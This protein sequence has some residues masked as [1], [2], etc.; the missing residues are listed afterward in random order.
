MTG[1]LRSVLRLV[2]HAA[3][4]A[5]LLL[6]A[7]A[8]TATEA[9]AQGL[10]LPQLSPAAEVKQQVGIG[11]ITVRYASPAV[12][13]RKIFGTLVPFGELWRTGANGA[14]TIEFTHDVSVSGTAVPAGKYSVFS[15]PGKDEWTLIL[16]KN[17]NQGGTRNYK[18]DLD[19][20]RVKV[21]PTAIAPREALTFLFSETTP[22]GT[23][24][25]LEWETTRVSLP[26][27]AETPKQVADGIKGFTG[28][29]AG[30]IANV[31]RYH[32]DELKDLDGALR[33]ID[34]AIALDK[35]WFNTWLKAK[36]LA[37]KGDH[38]AAY[39]LAEQA[40]EMGNKADYFFWKDDVKK[41]LDEWKSKK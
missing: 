30:D 18:Q 33:T 19:A 34:I 1:L 21:K 12:R 2:P 37:A 15:L 32:A 23:R 17:A 28:K 5:P 8:L 26:I 16:N 39:P 27:T 31:A 35:T 13:G 38:K 25:D 41:A 36:F 4:A 6:G 24:L 29:T 11:H 14:T 3:L 7:G 9:Q 22:A 10:A 20:V 40:W